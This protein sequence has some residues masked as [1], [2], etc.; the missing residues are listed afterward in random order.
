M[1]QRG[2]RLFLPEQRRQRREIGARR[3]VVLAHQPF[4]A[5]V[6]ER[7]GQ[8]GVQLVHHGVVVGERTWPLS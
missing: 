8:P 6:F 2:Q 7:V 4:H 5:L 1:V 3:S